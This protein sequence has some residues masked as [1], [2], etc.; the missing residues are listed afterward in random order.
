MVLNNKVIY[1][2]LLTVI[3]LLLFIPF[4]G[5]CHL[6]DWDEV[7]F[8]ECAR[9]MVVSGN[10]AYAQ[11]NYKP[12][13]EKP[14]LFIWLQAVS[15]LIFGVNEF[16]AR[17]PNAIC[18]VFSLLFIFYLGS[19]KHDT[20]FGFY[21]AIVYIAT[22]LPHFYF[23]SGIIDPWFNLFIFY[24]TWQAF[25]IIQADKK[26]YWV[27]IILG[28]TALGLAVLTKGP[29][30]LVITLLTLAVYIIYNRNY[31]ALLNYRLWL[32]G[33]VSIL[34]ALSWFIV[35][36]IN[37]KQGIIL[38]FI[39]YQVRL[40]ETGDAGHSGPFFYHILVILIGCFPA[41]IIF[42]SNLKLNKSQT[43]PQIEIKKI[44]LILFFVVLILFSIVKTKIVHY[45]SLTYF[46]LTFVAAEFLHSIQYSKTLGRW[47]KIIYWSIAGLL[48]LAFTLV[49]TFKFYANR[50]LASGLIKDEFTIGNLSAKAN[51]MG[52]EILVPITFLSASV[53]F[54]RSV[55]HQNRKTSL[56]PIALSMFITFIWLTIILIIPRV[57]EYTQQAAINFYKEKSKEHCYIET[58]GFKS[59]AFLFYSNRLP[60]DYQN[61]H[62]ILYIQNQLNEMEKEGHSR[63]TSYGLCNL[64]WMEHG[65]TDRVSYIVT[66]PSEKKEIEKFPWITK[67]Y[68]K[69]GYVFYKREPG[70]ATPY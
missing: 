17:F 24:S 32:Y 37:G 63:I 26:N 43:P 28:G 42:L 12:F 52:L 69:N 46:P 2:V 49:S 13:W 61:P 18:G 65:K 39:E 10:Y 58:Q 45:S 66:K 38:E 53:L 6:F 41:S 30:A 4:A 56:I 31:R 5:N 33:V 64:F 55:L 7:N 27:K 70:P 16:A 67:L 48:T 44:L 20:K 47:L 3:A 62:Q 8:A 57:E 22:L 19:K 51:W 25:E 15:M 1:N 60:S 14:P 59:Y 68:E 29:A 36:W 50:L 35:Q 21:W 34:T 40:F 11:I 23:R 9:E 54:Y